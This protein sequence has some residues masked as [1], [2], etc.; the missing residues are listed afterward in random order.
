MPS[1]SRAARWRAGNSNLR[2]RES[3]LEAGDIPA[4]LLRIRP[5]SVRRGHSEKHDFDG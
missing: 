5:N 3:N 2:R 4:T 1:F